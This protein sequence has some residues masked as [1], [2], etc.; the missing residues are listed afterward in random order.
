MAE[1][2]YAAA[3]ERDPTNVAARNNLS[4]TL[5]RRGCVKDAKREIVR[6]LELAQ[7]TSL[8]KDVMAT[9]TRLQSLEDED[10]CPAS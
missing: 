1:N 8:E 9:A 10:S 6:A 4:E 3:L 5:A 7:G 2:A